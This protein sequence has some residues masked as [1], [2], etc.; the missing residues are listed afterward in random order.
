MRFANRFCCSAAIVLL[1][2]G[3]VYAQGAPET[4]RAIAGGGI[5]V[6]G[7][8]GKIDAGAEKQGQTVNDDKFAPEGKGMRVT[9]GPAVTYWNPKNVAKGTIRFR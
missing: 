4:A 3:V 6:P 5:T 2:A 8:Q 9:T 1:S 7:W